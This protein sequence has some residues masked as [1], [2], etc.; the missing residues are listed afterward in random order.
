METKEFFKKWVKALRSGD[1][2]QV[3]GSLYSETEDAFC[4]LGVGCMVATKDMHP[5]HLYG[6]THPEDVGDYIESDP[7]VEILY[8]P[9][10]DTIKNQAVQD[11]NHPINMAFFDE[12]VQRN[13]ETNQSLT[14]LADYIEYEYAK[15]ILG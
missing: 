4:V 14:D 9:F 7:E 13:D 10:F 6:H 8:E 1:Y 15:D 5:S 12:L 3:E 11:E 2:K